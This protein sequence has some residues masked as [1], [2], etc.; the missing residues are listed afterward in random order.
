M[1]SKM[2]AE[3]TMA[4]QCDGLAPGCK[5][6]RGWVEIHW[7]PSESVEIHCNSLVS[8]GIHRISRIVCN[9]TK[10]WSD[11]KTNRITTSYF[12]H[13]ARY[14]GFKRGLCFVVGK[15][16]G[17]EDHH[18]VRIESWVGG[19]GRLVW[20]EN[21]EFSGLCFLSVC[22]SNWNDSRRGR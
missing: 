6:C 5:G 13:Q 18:Q 8:I 4:M 10:Q 1:V 3:M 7:N 21:S 22:L 15:L 2:L 17:N 14:P 20:L 11:T 16:V 9:N 12:Y 19:L